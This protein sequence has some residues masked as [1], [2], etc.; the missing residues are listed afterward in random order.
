MENQKECSCCRKDK[1]LT[2]FYKHKKS[3][4]GLGSWCKGCK[5]V[6]RLENLEKVKRY[7]RKSYIKKVNPNYTGRICKNCTKALLD[8]KNV[9][10]F[11][12]NKCYLMYDEELFKTD[13]INFKKHIKEM[14]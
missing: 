3:A 5:T 11:C 8:P 7:R 10:D 12:S 14:V 1:P 4:D 9:G 2:E 13:Y 6:W